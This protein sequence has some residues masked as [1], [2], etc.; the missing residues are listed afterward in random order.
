MNKTDE[1]I[2]LIRAWGLER[3]ITGVEAKASPASQYRKLLEEVGELGEGLIKE[4][5]PEVIDAIGDCTVVLIL[6]CDLLGLRFD[7]C[8]D[9]AYNVIRHRKGK[10]VGGAFVREKDD[11]LDEPLGEKQADCDGEACESCT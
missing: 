11:D 7:E 6:L 9:S 8:L 3:N 10:K 2:S 4:D 1:L 5:E